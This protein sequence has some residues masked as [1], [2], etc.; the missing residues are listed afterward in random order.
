MELLMDKPIVEGCRAVVVGGMKP[1]KGTHV[2]VGEFIGSVSG[3]LYHDHWAVDKPLMSTK[4]VYINS[5]SES[6]L[7]RID[8]YNGNETVSWESCQWQPEKI[9]PWA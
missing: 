4:G 7:K 6:R 9:K 2:V 8:D 3:F 1:N 5:I